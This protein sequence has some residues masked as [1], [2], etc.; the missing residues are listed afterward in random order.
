MGAELNKLIDQFYFH[1]PPA[2]NSSYIDRE[3]VC[4]KIGGQPENVP[5]D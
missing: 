3:H 5:A 4:L 2:E 1:K